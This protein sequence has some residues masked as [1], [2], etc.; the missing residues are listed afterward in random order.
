MKVTKNELPEREIELTVELIDEDLNP[1]MERAYQKVGQQA[2]IDGF[3]K[4]KVPKSILNSYFGVEYIK[5]EAFNLGMPS[6][7]QEAIVD[8]ANES[9]GR[10]LVNIVSEDPLTLKINIGLEPKVTLDAYT[11]I[12]VP[13]ESVTI[14]EEQ[15]EAVITDL[16]WANSNWIPMERAVQNDDQITIDL[17]AKVGDKEVA[18]QQDVIYLV[19]EHNNRPVEGFH[20]YLL[21]M[22]VNDT[23]TFTIPFPEEY[24]DKEVAGKECE[25]TVTLKDVKAK[26]L[27]ELDDEFAKG[28]GDG[29]DSVDALREQIKNNLFEN[30]N[31]TAQREYENKI[32][33]ELKN[34]AT[35]EVSPI[36][37]DQETQ[38][39]IDNQAET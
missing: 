27:A 13:K 22:V 11:E 15:I 10:P 28:I 17:I 24:E 1:F 16:R 26:D 39:I 7:V 2:K 6:I 4:G 18:N 34:R 23:K 36:L 38:A 31:T 19:T 9:V 30:A 21:D 33:E 35:L 12:R 14:P 8:N 20:A 32:L 29:F 3:R 5:N 25:F 37:I